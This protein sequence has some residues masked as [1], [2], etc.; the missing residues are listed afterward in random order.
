MHSRSP[1]HLPQARQI[2]GETERGR[3]P[4]RPHT[5][6]QDLINHRDLPP[7][8]RTSSK[9]HDLRECRNQDHGGPCRAAFTPFQADHGP[10]L[11]GSLCDAVLVASLGCH[12]R[13]N[14]TRDCS[15]CGDLSQSALSS[16]GEDQ[17]VTASSQCDMDSVFGGA[18]TLGTEDTRRGPLCPTTVS[19]LRAC[20]LAG[21]SGSSGLRTARYAA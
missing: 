16:P 15:G 6:R 13:T 8:E 17:A 11:A 9:S 19:E 5:N 14:R 7:S 20:R 21:S 12:S 2:A 4:R 18:R 3:R 10:W 1:C